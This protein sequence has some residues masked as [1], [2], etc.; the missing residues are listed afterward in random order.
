MAIIDMKRGDAYIVRAYRGE[1]LIFER[2]EPYIASV[3]E[4]LTGSGSYI[5]IDDLELMSGYT[6]EVDFIAPDT[7]PQI[8]G[9]PHC[10]II[11]GS[12]TK[13]YNSS[14]GTDVYRGMFFGFPYSAYANLG[15]G[16]RYTDF[17]RN[18]GLA[19]KVQVPYTVG[20]RQTVSISY[21]N[22]DVQTL[23]DG[24]FYLFAARAYDLD[25]EWAPADGQ[26]HNEHTLRLY[27]VNGVPGFGK[28]FRITIKD[29]NNNILKNFLPKVVGGHKGMIDTVSNS[30]YQAANDDMFE[31][32]L[33]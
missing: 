2:G 15:L 25:N 14:W 13:F 18:D 31:I 33:G 26:I 7:Y 23:T 21:T 27:G 8:A 28:Y 10:C 16:I 11:G 22:S 20:I 1:D 12:Y 24:G 19:P 32:G 9:N 30:F 4:A 17:A 3:G 6:Y 5:Y 29:A